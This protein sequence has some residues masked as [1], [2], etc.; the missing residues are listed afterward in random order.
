MRKG[1]FAVNAN[2]KDPDQPAE[3]YSLFK[4]YT[5]LRYVPQ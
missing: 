1:I 2:T 5:I 4:N 3:I